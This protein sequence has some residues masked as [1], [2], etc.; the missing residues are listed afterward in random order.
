[1]VRFE[2]SALSRVFD[3]NSCV[4]TFSLNI[5]F[6]EF[7]VEVDEWLSKFRDLPFVLS[8]IGFEIE[9]GFWSFLMFCLNDTCHK[10]LIK[11]VKWT[12][13]KYADDL[14]S[15]TDWC[16]FVTFVNIKR[17]RRISRLFLSFSLFFILIFYKIYH[18]VEYLV[19]P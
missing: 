4:V 16:T 9:S 18:I 5:F 3:F 14:E 6:A 12:F 11:P 2:I 13:I 17:S 15:F 19:L 1:M 8:Q 7:L 10:N